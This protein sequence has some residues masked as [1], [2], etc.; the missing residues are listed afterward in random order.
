LPE[1]NYRIHNPNE[2]RRNLSY[3]LHN[4]LTVFLTPF[5]SYEH[6]QRFYLYRQGEMYYSQDARTG[7]QQSL[8]TKNRHEAQRL[9]E[10]KRQATAT[11]PS[12]RSS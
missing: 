9:L 5:V 3:V 11:L 10:I 7:K 8:E 12:I 2:F 4:T 6:E 1:E